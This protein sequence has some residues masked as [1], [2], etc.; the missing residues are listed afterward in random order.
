M[1]R[2]VARKVQSFFYIP[3]TQ[4]L[5]MLMSYITMIIKTKKLTLV[6]PFYTFQFHLN[7]TI[8]PLLSYFCSQIPFRISH[9]IYLKKKFFY[10][11]VIA[12]QCC[13]SFCDTMKWVSYMYTYIPFLLNAFLSLPSPHSSTQV[14][15]EYPVELPSSFPLAV[16]LTLGSVHMSDLIFQLY[17]CHISY[18]YDI[19]YIWYIF[20]I[21]DNFLHD[22]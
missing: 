22:T 19:S 11:S 21:C 5:L 12:L 2:K 18:A 9:C 17:I 3:F 6:Q 4:L 13:V 14:I 10:W 20:S 1:Y 16:Y 8:F 7:F 15:T